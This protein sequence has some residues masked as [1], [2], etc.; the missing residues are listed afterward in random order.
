MADQLPL[1]E[2]ATAAAWSSGGTAGD[3]AAPVMAFVAHAKA[4]A[5]DGLTLAEFSELLVALV[6]TAMQVVNVFPVEGQAK[7]AFVVSS[8]GM[9]FDHVAD[10]LIPA[11]V[12]PVWLIVRPWARVVT[13]ALASGTVEALL[14]TVRT[15]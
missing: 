2:A 4:A 1:G 14:P 5:A 15:E 7:K 9:L 12:W 6:R 11:Y 10:H 3:A 13:L 8:A